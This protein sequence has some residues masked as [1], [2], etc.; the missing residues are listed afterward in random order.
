MYKKLVFQFDL[1]EIDDWEGGNVASNY[2]DIL[3]VTINGEDKTLGS[4]K[5]EFDEGVIDD[6]FGDIHFVSTSLGAPSQLGFGTPVDQIH[7]VTVEI[8][9][10]YVRPNKSI[11]LGFKTDFTGGGEESAGFDNVQL[12]AVCD[13]PLRAPSAA[14]TRSNQ[15]RVSRNTCPPGATGDPHI[16]GWSCKFHSYLFCYG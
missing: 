1:Y 3:Y 4:Y 16:K 9:Y 10:R 8:P 14:P 11:T 6:W 2:A 13:D 15:K 7:R 12:F 5:N